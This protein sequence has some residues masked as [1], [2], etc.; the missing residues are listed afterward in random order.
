MAKVTYVEHN[1]TQHVVDLDAG[2]SLM[3]GAVRN[4]IPGIT[5]DCGGAG[6][7]ATCHIYVDGDWSKKI[8]P[9]DDMERSMLECVEDMAPGSRLAC[10]ILVSGA[11]DGIAVR[12]PRCQRS[13]GSS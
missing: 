10:Q 6:S 13:F 2:L 11:C 7:C 9:M 1:G 3:E 5:A 4:L 8:S 12:L